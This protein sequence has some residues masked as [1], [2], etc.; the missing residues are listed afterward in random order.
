[1]GYIFNDTRFQERFYSALL[2][3]IYVSTVNDMRQDKGFKCNPEQGR[4]ALKLARLKAQAPSLSRIALQE[5][6]DY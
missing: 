3:R 1:M 4:F 2:C 6:H 5:T